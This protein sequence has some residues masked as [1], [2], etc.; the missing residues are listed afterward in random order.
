MCVVGIRSFVTDKMGYRGEQFRNKLSRQIHN[1]DRRRHKYSVCV[2]EITYRGPN[3]NE[4]EK[5]LL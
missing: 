3:A 2:T 4:S 1:H 5:T